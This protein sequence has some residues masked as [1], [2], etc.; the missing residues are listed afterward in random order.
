MRKRLVKIVVST[1][2]FWPTGQEFAA[3]IMAI[4]EIRGWT[5]TTALPHVPD[6][7]RGVINLRGM[8]L[9]VIDLKA[10]L[11]L[12]LTEATPKHVIIVVNADDRTIGLLVDAV[13]DIPD[14]DVRG[15]PIRSRRHAGKS[16]R[17]TSRASPFSTGAWSRCSE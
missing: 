17:T 14:R 9:P 6:Y 8:V 10:R 12:G 11:G 13:S 5:D 15:N 4:R 1:S 3:D 2:H 7:V 16:K